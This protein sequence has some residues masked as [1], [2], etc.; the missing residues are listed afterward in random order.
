MLV[1]VASASTS[2]RGSSD[3]V[4][5]EQKGLLAFKMPN[6]GRHHACRIQYNLTKM[7]AVSIVIPYLNENITLIRQTAGSILQNTPPELLD[8]ILFVDDANAAEN[9]HA[10]ELR[11]LHPKIK[12]HRNEERQ[13]LIK[14]KITG[15]ALTTSSVIVFLEPH[16]RANRQWLEPLLM[17]LSQE[18]QSL[19]VPIVDVIPQQS[20]DEYTYMAEQWGGFDWGLT[21]IWGGLNKKRDKTWDGISAFPMP[22][23]SG[24]L[25]AVTR[26]WWQRSGTYDSQMT[27]WGGENIEQ[28][29][30][31]WR[32]GGSIKALPCSRVGHM[33][34]K[35]R[36]YALNNNKFLKNNQRLAAVW[37]N[38]EDNSDKMGKHHDYLKDLSHAGSVDDRLA[39]K[40][41][42]N[43]KS[44]D[45]YM[46]NVYPELKLKD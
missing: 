41:Q 27:E 12:V 42:L 23:L 4:G 18:P 11:A 46:T 21:Y 45:W 44:M 20:T 34:R 6:D 25:F 40:K 8:Q 3:A 33:F 10:D 1:A 38:N 13:G 14:A 2:F 26:D 30:R 19:A 22:A 7:P 39:L 35:S 15:A 29:L 37:L 28:S 31:V 17:Q 24:G 9:S 43:C 32:C 16:I 5:G 36:P